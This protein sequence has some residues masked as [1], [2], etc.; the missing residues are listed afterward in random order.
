MQYCLS[1]GRIVVN[2]YCWLVVTYYTILPISRKSA[3]SLYHT[4]QFHWFREIRLRRSPFYSCSDLFGLSSD[5]QDGD[6]N[7]RYFNGSKKLLMHK[8]RRLHVLCQH[9]LWF[10]HYRKYRSFIVWIRINHK[11]RMA[12]QTTKLYRQQLITGSN[13]THVNFMNFLLG[14]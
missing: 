12:T 10:E 14:E 8:I 3:S 4:S 7:R 1:N 2:L 6:G 9:L 13:I 11:G 5:H